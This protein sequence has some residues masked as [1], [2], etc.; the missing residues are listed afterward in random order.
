MSDTRV[1]IMS[2]GY[3]I[4]L[5]ALLPRAGIGST[6]IV[7]PNAALEEEGSSLTV[8]QSFGTAVGECVRSSA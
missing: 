4:V 5:S 3:F 6:E 1:V 7:I 2:L 8:S